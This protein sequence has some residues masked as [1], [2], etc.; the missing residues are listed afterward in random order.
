[1]KLSGQSRR[2]A[3]RQQTFAFCC[4]SVK[5]LP[6]E[7]SDRPAG[8]NDRSLGTEWTARADSDRCRNRL[9]NCNPRFYAAAVDQHR[10]HGLGNAVS[11]DFGCA[12][13]GHEA[14][15]NAANY[16]HKNYPGSKLVMSRAGE[17]G[18][19]AMRSEER[20]VG[21]ECRSRWS[22]YH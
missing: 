4:G 18:N 10:F 11:L 16:R 21:K 1:M 3:A 19:E 13:F 14:D 20:R 17:F 7:R 8:L 6:D 9:Q 22:P 5:S 12:V 15:N 2:R